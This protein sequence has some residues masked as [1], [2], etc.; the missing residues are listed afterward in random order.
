MATIKPKAAT[1]VVSKQTAIK[2]YKKRI[3]ENPAPVLAEDG[4]PLT[5]EKYVEGFERPPVGMKT[6][7][8][9]KKHLN[10]NYEFNAELVRGVHKLEAQAT[11]WNTTLYKTASEHLYTILADVY[12][13]Y[14]KLA[15]AEPDFKKFRAGLKQ[16]AADKGVKVKASTGAV[17]ILVNCVFKDVPSQRRSAYG[18]GL[19]ALVATYGTNMLAEEVVVKI[20]DAGGIYE[21]A[22][23]YP[24]PDEAK[25]TKAEAK[26]GE[27]EALVKKVCGNTLLT[28]KNKGFADLLAMPN[29]PYL[30][31][32]SKDDA[33]VITVSA[34]SDTKTAVH[35]AAKAIVKNGKEAAKPKNVGIKLGEIL[36]EQYEEV[37]LAEV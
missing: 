36:P 2:A 22:C 17:C 24:E 29:V 12:V 20:R 33:G 4:L 14:G 10:S 30:A 28:I 35:G 1:K 11:K 15:L 25:V 32:V 37:A 16:Y 26:E 13:L 34:I 8:V 3:K 19:Q 5:N 6:A 9:S 18:L 7:N 31:F 21:L 27:K 23:P